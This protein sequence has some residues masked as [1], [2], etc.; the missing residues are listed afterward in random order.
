MGPPFE[1]GCRSQMEVHEHLVI[2]KPARA[3]QAHG[4]LGG[5]L[6]VI[7]RLK[8][9]LDRA[10]GNQAGREGP[11]DKIQSGDH[12]SPSGSTSRSKEDRPGW[13]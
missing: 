2:L 5:S 13:H 7:R 6:V 10:A 11:L 8:R 3:D 9:V 12:L 4:I 1:I